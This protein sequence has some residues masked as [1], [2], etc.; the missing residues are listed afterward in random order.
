MAGNDSLDPVVGCVSVGRVVPVER[1]GCLAAR[2]VKAGR[3]MLSAP[4]PLRTTAPSNA[5][6]E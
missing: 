6:E 5:A 2:W 1:D 4:S 3:V